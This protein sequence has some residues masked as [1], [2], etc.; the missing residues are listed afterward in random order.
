MEITTYW[1]GNR[2]NREKSVIHFFN[3]CC[4]TLKYPFDQSLIYSSLKV[5]S[6]DSDTEGQ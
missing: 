1:T 5:D 6:F 3:K 2:L 4:I